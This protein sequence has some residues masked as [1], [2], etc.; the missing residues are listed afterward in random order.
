MRPGL[1]VRPQLNPDMTISRIPGA[2]TM[3]A[4]TLAA[5]TRVAI[6]ITRGHEVRDTT[7]DNHIEVVI[8]EPDKGKVHQMTGMMIVT[9]MIEDTIIAHLH[10]AL[11]VEDGQAVIQA[12]AQVVV[13]AVQTRV[14]GARQVDAIMMHGDVGNQ[15]DTA[16]A[17]T[18]EAAGMT[19]REIM[20]IHFQMR[21]QHQDLV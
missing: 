7:K 12:G 10:E 14:T 4:K 19:I 13:V 1:L 16:Q 11:P 8:M 9:L 3:I 5:R 17:G 6:T 21:H 20:T 15:A 18:R 2:R